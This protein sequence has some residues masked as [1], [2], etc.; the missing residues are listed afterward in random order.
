MSNLTIKVAKISA[1]SSFKASIGFLSHEWLSAYNFAKG[2]LTVKWGENMSVYG[3]IVYVQEVIA[4][5]ISNGERKIY[6]HNQ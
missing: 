4:K 6:S 3:E 1:W 2:L 5:Q